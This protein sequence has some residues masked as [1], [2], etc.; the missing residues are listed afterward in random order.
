MAC[1]QVASPYVGLRP[2][3]ETE[4]AFFF[5][6]EHD[7][8]IITTN[9][10]EEPLTVI[11]GPSGAGKSS[12]LQAGV[13]PYLKSLPD[14][15]VVYFRN[16]QGGT[17]QEEIWQKVPASLGQVPPEGSLQEIVTSAKKKIFLLLD[18]F[19]EYLLYHWTGRNGDPFET[20]LARIVNRSDIQA[21]VLIGLREDGLSRLNERFAIRIPDLLGNTLQVERL[22]PASA[23]NAIRK[24]L[25]VFSRT[26][27]AKGKT[28]SIEDSLV[29][30]ILD[31][32][33]EGGAV[34]SD[35]AGK[36]TRGS[37]ASAQIETAYLQLVLTRLW[38]EE[39]GNGSTILHLDTFRTLG[40]A[41]TIVRNHVR[42]VLESLGNE[43]LR[44]IAAR[45]F[46]YLVTPSRTKIAQ[47]TE[48]LVTFGKAPEPEVKQVLNTLADLEQTRILRRLSNPEQYEIFHDVLAQ[49]ILDWCRDREEKKRLEEQ[50][51]RQKEEAERRQHELEQAQALAE[52]AKKLAQEQELRAEQAKK[53]ADEQELRANEQ[54]EAAHQLRRMVGILIFLVAFAV[55]AA[56]YGLWEQRK[57]KANAAEAKKNAAA[58]AASAA[59]ARESEAKAQ[60]AFLE[61]KLAQAKQADDKK[62]IQQYQHQ[63]DATRKAADD[64]ARQAQQQ[65]SAA[66]SAAQQLKE[67]TQERDSLKDQVQQQQENLIRAK[68]D[69]DNLSEQL[70]TLQ[71]QIDESH[72]LPSSVPTGSNATPRPGFSNKPTNAQ[73][74][75]QQVAFNPNDVEATWALAP[76]D[77]AASMIAKRPRD[78]KKKP[79][80]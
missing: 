17:F 65:G 8:G 21:R 73:S 6:R 54:A 80:G 42:S 71:K 38:K 61:S 67:V 76:L 33:Q 12:V 27:Q 46:V 1:D 35:S 69:H 10:I 13:V 43:T 40:G 32:V 3:S 37:N 36:G 62:A 50:E 55:A 68:A 44:D 78:F 56:I 23:R 52:Q 75:P 66:L 31:Q 60:Q 7:I 9:I 70:K 77:I 2:F 26:P 24:P 47:R 45:L 4:Q 30:E 41:N 51:K 22:S 58:A 25:Q 5:G 64:A 34:T 53:L 29:E 11:Y 39:S 57:A 18:Q 48:D 63:I 20:T 28:F 19:E 79:I 74:L 72:R 15:S 49:H 14:T 16:W 59:L